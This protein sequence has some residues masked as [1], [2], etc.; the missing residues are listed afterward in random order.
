MA[1]DFA[2]SS[3]RLSTSAPVTAPGFVVSAWFN[4]PANDTIR[5]IL[6]IRDTGTS[7][8]YWLIRTQG[9]GSNDVA[10]VANDGTAIGSAIAV[11]GYT[12]NTWTHVLYR[13]RH[14]SLR[15]IYVDGVNIDSDSTT[16]NPSSIDSLWLGD[17][18]LS[19]YTGELAEVAIWDDPL[20][21]ADIPKMAE[22]LAAGFPPLLAHPNNLVYYSPLIN[23]EDEYDIVGGLQLTETGSVGVS[24]HPTI[25][26]PTISIVGK[27]STISQDEAAHCLIF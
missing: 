21:N 9:F 3:N 27:P 17:Y 14:A 4:A 7:T 19:E 6:A 26:K 15:V 23:G 22:S 2:G 13:E 25:I 11:G 24:A 20:P 18:T 16:V 12:P 5:T 10:V 8:N 1:R